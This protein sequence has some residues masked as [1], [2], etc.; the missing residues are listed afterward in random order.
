MLPLKTSHP[1]TGKIIFF[2]LAT[3]SLMPF[4]PPAAALIS[5]IA[6][7]FLL[8]NPFPKTTK[9]VSGKLLK[10][11]VVCLGFGI[12]LQEAMKTGEKGFITTFFSVTIVMLIGYWLGR[13]FSI[14]N[15]TSYLISSGTAICGGSAIAAVGPAIDAKEVDMSVSLVTIF[16]LNAV[17]LLIFPFLGHLFNLDQHQ[18]GLWAAIS[19][20]DTSSVVGAGASYGPEALKIATMVKL[21]RAL[22]VIPLVLVSSLFFRNK[23]KKIS[24]PWFILFF[25]LAMFAAA[26]LPIPKPVIEGIV[27]LSKRILTLTLFLIGAGLSREAVK[28]VGIK[29][30]LMGVVLWFVIGVLG[31]L[32]A[33]YVPIV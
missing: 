10:V 1:L 13:K 20:H 27:Y 21:T 5:G 6:L 17:A 14:N 23:N 4:I 3:L 16:L 8:S 25:V 2:L 33:R 26:Y 11:A 24:I 32:I 29:P 31:F 30:M 15:K 12:N 7:S 19:I 22:W 9:K 28:V 18:F